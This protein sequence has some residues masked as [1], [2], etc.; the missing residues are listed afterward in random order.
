MPR[1]REYVALASAWND[2]PRF[3]ALLGYEYTSGLGDRSVYFRGDDGALLS[4]EKY[5]SLEDF[6]A[7][8][9]PGEVVT[10]PHHPVGGNVAPSVNWS[11]HDPRFQ[12]AVEI[13]STH[14]DAEYFS[15]PLAAV[16]KKPGNRKL[17]LREGNVQAALASGIDLSFLASTDNHFAAR[18][19][20]IRL[21][22]T[23]IPAGPGLCAA[24]LAERSRGA[25]F[26]AIVHGGTYR[27]TGPRIRIELHPE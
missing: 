19:S 21:G 9:P 7:Q 16:A 4:A 2:P 11:F 26:E 13:F 27:T 14:G 5:P 20:P 18:G 6:W 3:I 22:N 17:A 8:L 12:R 1:W 23:E 24:W 25:F 15:T 10:I